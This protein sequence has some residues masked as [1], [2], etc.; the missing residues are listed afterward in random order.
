[1]ALLLDLLGVDFNATFDFR[2]Y[3]W[4]T[5]PAI[6][7]DV[8]VRPGAECSLIQLESVSFFAKHV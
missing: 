5:R 2:L 4:I 1:V 7:A 6:G 3:R 8:M